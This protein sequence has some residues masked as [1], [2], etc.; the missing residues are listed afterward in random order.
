MLFHPALGIEDIDTTDSVLEKREI[1]CKE[2]SSNIISS[3]SSSLK[4]Y[5]RE[6]DLNNGIPAIIWIPVTKDTKYTA[7]VRLLISGFRTPDVPSY[8]RC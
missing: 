5:L 6:G 7:K 1:E 4:C 8:V 2:L 3:S